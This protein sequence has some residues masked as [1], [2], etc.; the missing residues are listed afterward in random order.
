MKGFISTTSYCY[1]Q[2]TLPKHEETRVFM[3]EKRNESSLLDVSNAHKQIDE[4][5]HEGWV[6]KA[7]RAFFYD[8]PVLLKWHHGASAVVINGDDITNGVASCLRGTFSGQRKSCFLMFGQHH[9]L[10]SNGKGE[11]LPEPH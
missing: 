11:K 7:H 5:R 6:H 2:P 3:V 8:N 4:L 10:C 9:I 1:F